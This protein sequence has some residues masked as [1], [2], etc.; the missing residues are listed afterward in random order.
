MFVIYRVHRTD[1]TSGHPVSFHAWRNE[2]AMKRSVGRI[3]WGLPRGDEDLKRSGEWDQEDSSIYSIVTRGSRQTLRCVRVH[4]A[5]D[6][7]RFEQSVSR[8]MQEV[9]FCFLCKRRRSMDVVA[10]IRLTAIKVRV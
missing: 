10:S 7:A 6:F 9:Q 1:H 4:P 5:N 2:I 3:T 8:A